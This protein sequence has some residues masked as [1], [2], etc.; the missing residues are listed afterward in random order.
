MATELEI[1]VEEEPVVI[2]SEIDIQ[3]PAPTPKQDDSVLLE[4]DDA[5]SAEGEQEVGESARLKVESEGGS[6][7]SNAVSGPE[8]LQRFYFESDALVLKNNAE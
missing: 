1:A 7:G 4:T 6:D 3:S 8:R 5:P 2:G